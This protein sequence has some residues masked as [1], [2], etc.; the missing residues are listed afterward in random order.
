LVL[1][2]RLFMLPH[3][4]QDFANADSAIGHARDARGHEMFGYEY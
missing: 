1:N 3:P 4:T 2:K